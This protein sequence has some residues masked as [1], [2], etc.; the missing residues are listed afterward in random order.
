MVIRSDDGGEFKEGR[1]GNSVEK[2]TQSK[3]S[4]P[5]ADSP[6]YN[7]FKEKKFF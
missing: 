6:E 5:T 7:V 2:E 4:Q 1:F 3:N